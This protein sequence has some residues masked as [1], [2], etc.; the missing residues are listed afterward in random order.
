VSELVRIIQHLVAYDVVAAPDFYSVTIPGKRQPE[1]HIRS[2]EKMLDGIFALDDRP[3]LVARSMDKRLA[4]RCHHFMLLLAAMLRAKSIPAR[5]GFG[6][7]FNPP[8]RETEDR[9]RHS[10]HSRFEADRPLI[11]LV[12]PL[13]RFS[14]PH[15]L[16][17][18]NH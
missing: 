8:S 13:Q 3:L 2:I 15:Q 18:R 4:G 9:S 17:D 1:I 11:R 7:Y 10:G 14:L 6:S 5:C 16:R 12:H